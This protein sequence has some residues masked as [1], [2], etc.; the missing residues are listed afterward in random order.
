MADQLDAQRG[1]D[2]LLKLQ[3]GATVIGARRKLGYE[4]VGFRLCPEA[5]ARGNTE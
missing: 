1:R 4:V 5:A 3:F 2:A